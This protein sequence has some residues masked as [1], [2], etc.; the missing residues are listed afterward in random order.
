MDE[1]PP[2]P[3]IDPKQ[4]LIAIAKPVVRTILARLV[5]TGVIPKQLDDET[6]EGL[7]GAVL[8]HFETMLAQITSAIGMQIG[9]MAS[10]LASFASAMTQ[11]NP[12]IRVVAIPRDNQPPGNPPAD[13]PRGA[14]RNLRK[15]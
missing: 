7:T 8:G 1:Q 14:K 13:S 4:E 15:V 11:N 10:D 5:L 9:G 6:I 12:E 2:K 3:S